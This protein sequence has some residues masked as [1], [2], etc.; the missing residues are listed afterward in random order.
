[1]PALWSGF[2]Q[3]GKTRQHRYAACPDYRKH[4]EARVIAKKVHEIVDLHAV[5][6]WPVRLRQ[7]VV[8]DVEAASFD[9]G[10]RIV[11]RF[12]FTGH[13]VGKYEVEA[14]R[15]APAT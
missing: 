2:G 8:D 12:E 6:I 10:E 9:H 14:L 13:R 11:E 3:R 1:M 7:Q 15:R 5:V 4:R